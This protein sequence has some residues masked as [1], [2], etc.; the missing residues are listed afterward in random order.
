MGSAVFS[1]GSRRE[2]VC[3]HQRTRED[4]RTSEAGDPRGV[5]GGPHLQGRSTRPG[6]SQVLVSVFM[7]FLHNSMND[8][9]GRV[10]FLQSASLSFTNNW[11]LI[12]ADFQ[13]LSPKAG[14]LCFPA[15]LK[16]VLRPKQVCN[17]PAL[18]S[19][20]EASAVHRTRLTVF[21]PIPG[22]PSKS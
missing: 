2:D 3:C 1:N 4:Q 11:K 22:P 16:P 14:N 18:R 6:T 15:C 5:G 7:L 20:L 12:D 13:K 17:H 9:R 10:S 19:L 21:P 8:Y